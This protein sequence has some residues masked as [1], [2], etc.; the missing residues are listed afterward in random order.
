[1]T[2]EYELDC[3]YCI[4]SMVRALAICI[5]HLKVHLRNSEIVS[6]TTVVNHEPVDAGITLLKGRAIL[7]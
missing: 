5:K 3:M 4:E 1:M 2:A 6:V 7:G